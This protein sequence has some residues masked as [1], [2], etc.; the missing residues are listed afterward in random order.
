MQDPT[1]PLV[2]TAD[3]DGL[4]GAFTVLDTHAELNHRYRKLIEDS[5]AQL[6]AERVRLTQARGMA[7]KVQV[8][9]RA[10]GPEFRDTLGE[11]ERT[12]LDAGLTQAETLIQHAHP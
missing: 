2:A 5:Y 10:A 11:P 7:K 8:L 6:A 3:L 12:A 4:A 9:V 1:T